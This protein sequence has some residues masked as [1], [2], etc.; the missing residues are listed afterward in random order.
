MVFL[1][2]FVK[3][4]GLKMTAAAPLDKQKFRLATKKRLLDRGE[5]ITE[6]ARR[7]GKSRVATSSAINHGMYPK[8]VAAIQEAL[9]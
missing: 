7:I 4:N 6:L 1:F 5:T 3:L 2:T 8:V 9:S